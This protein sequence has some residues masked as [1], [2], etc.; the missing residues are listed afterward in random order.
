MN[1]TKKI[2][3]ISLSV[4]LFSALAL[5][6]YAGERQEKQKESAEQEIAV[7]PDQLPAPVRHIAEKF[8]GAG[9]SYQ[10]TQEGDD[11]DL[12]YE[13]ETGKGN[14]A[15]SIVL[16]KEG[17]VVEIEESVPFVSLPA[18]AKAM[19]TQKYSSRSIKNV[20]R[21]HTFSYEVVIEKNGKEKELPITAFGELQGKKQDKEDQEMKEEK[22]G[23]NKRHDQEKDDDDEDVQE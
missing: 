17:Q 19:L 8:V 9:K 15:K 16:T 20:I 23:H 18:E 1:Q 3:T 6:V 4:V 13:I 10:A 7:T 5:L 12:S 21:V 22:H 11:D 14:E 2:F